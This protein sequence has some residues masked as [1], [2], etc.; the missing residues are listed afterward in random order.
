MSIPLRSAKS[1]A[2]IAGRTWSS[3]LLP[4]RHPTSPPL[5]QGYL[6]AGRVTGATPPPGSELVLTVGVGLGG[7]VETGAVSMSRR[8]VPPSMVEPPTP[9]N[10]HGQPGHQATRRGRPWRF[11]STCQR[12]RYPAAQRSSNPPLGP[13]GPVYSIAPPGPAGADR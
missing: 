3:G 1:W 8:V 13:E 11:G 9:H 4:P 7:S 12:S 6:A 5:G 2:L 10:P